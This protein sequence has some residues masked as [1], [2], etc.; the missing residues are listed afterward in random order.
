LLLQHSCKEKQVC[1]FI[2]MFIYLFRDKVSL[3]SPG[4]PGTHSVDQAGL[5]VRNLSA[6][7]SQVLGLKVCGTTVRFMCSFLTERPRRS[8]LFCV[9]VCVCVC[10]YVCLHA[11]LVIYMHECVC[12]CTHGDQRPASDATQPF[13]FFEMESLTNLELME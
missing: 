5:E 7:L 13:L 11:F 9:C 2:S 10:V 4:C 6:S 8:L 12:A 3:Y 1:L